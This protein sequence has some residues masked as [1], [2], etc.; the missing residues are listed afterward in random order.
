MPDV[1]HFPT[2]RDASRAEGEGQGW[3]SEQRLCKGCGTHFHPQRTWQK[4][5]SQR[6]RQRAYVQRHSAMPLS[7]YGA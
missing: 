7:Y 3:E 4:Q 2:L 6:C 5:C 1:T